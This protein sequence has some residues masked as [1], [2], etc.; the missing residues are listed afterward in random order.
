MKTGVQALSRQIEHK[1]L[2][3]EL[4]LYN[5]KGSLQEQYDE[6]P[7]IHSIWSYQED[8]KTIYTETRDTISDSQK[9]IKWIQTGLNSDDS[10]K[11]W[12]APFVY[13][14]IMLLPYIKTIKKGK[15]CIGYMVPF[16]LRATS[17]CKHLF[18]KILS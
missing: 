2:E 18:R 12:G 17:S 13:K 9:N 7:Y 8:D 10:T 16:Y 3:F 5:L 1:H 11:Q 14:D 4:E 15:E 6:N